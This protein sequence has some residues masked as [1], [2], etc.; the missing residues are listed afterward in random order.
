MLFPRSCGVSARRVVAMCR[1]T[2][3]ELYP[4]VSRHRDRGAA[5]MLRDLA[6]ANGY[7]FVSLKPYGVRGKWLLTLAY[8]D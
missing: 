8:P 2:L 6:V 7:R 4:L 3:A 5:L 1:L